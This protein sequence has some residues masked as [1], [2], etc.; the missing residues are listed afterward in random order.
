MKKQEAR[1]THQLAK[2]STIAKGTAASLRTGSKFELFNSTATSVR[3]GSVIARRIER[4]GKS[5]EIPMLIEEE[6]SKLAKRRRRRRKIG[7]IERDAETRLMRFN[8][9]T[10]LGFWK[11]PSPERKMTPLYLCFFFEET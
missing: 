9:G 3:S 8:I 4:R 7:D 2:N 5:L 6:R 1:L 11:A 10:R